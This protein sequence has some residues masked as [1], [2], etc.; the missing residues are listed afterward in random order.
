LF[1]ERAL[2]GRARNVGRTKSK[3]SPTLGVG[4]HR[5]TDSN[6]LRIAMGLCRRSGA[7]SHAANV[8]WQLQAVTNILRA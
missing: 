8:D 6:W 1:S 5:R 3:R 7:A 2:F 4:V